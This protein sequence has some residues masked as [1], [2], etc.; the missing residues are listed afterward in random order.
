MEKHRVNINI[1]GKEYSE[2]IEPRTLLVTFLR[3][4]AGLTGTHIGCDTSNCGA[5]TVIMNGRAVKSCTVLAVQA[6]GSKILT[7]EGFSKD[8]DKMNPIQKAFV[9]K[10]GYQCGYCT[11]GMILTALSLLNR[12]RNL[13]EDEIREAL[14][15][16]LCRCTGYDSIIDSIMLADSDMTKKKQEEISVE[17]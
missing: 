16:N 6:S 12:K 13:T 14:S 1:N 5:C 7:I 2:E 10:K 3:D 15:G 4:I 11:S 17:A 8:G 9:E